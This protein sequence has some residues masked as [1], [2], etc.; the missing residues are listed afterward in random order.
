MMNGLQLK[1]PLDSDYMTTVRLATGGVC[2][3]AGLD[4]NDSEDCKVCV[5]EC[6]LILMRNGFTSAEVTFLPQDGLG[7]KIIGKDRSGE[8]TPSVEDEISYALLGALVDNLQWEKG[9]ADMA[10][11]FRFGI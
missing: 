4:I 6:L 7:V 1:L 5:T 10:V 9:Q 3:L 11:T 2:S 8:V